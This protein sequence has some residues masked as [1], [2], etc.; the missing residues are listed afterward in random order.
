MKS[1]LPDVLPQHNER[2]LG[3]RTADEL[4]NDVKSGIKQAPM[5]VRLTP[6]LLSL[7][8]WSDPFH[9]PLVRQF[10]PLGSRMKP[11]HPQGSYDS[12]DET[13][14]SPVKGIIHRYL[15]KAAFL[16]RLTIISL[17]GVTD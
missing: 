9:D 13:G 5:A 14:D 12:L 11:D 10:I 4:I 16:G 2:E 3:I 15:D 7:I 6:H 17:Q 1:V 8:N